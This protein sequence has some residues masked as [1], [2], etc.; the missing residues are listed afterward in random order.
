MDSHRLLIRL[1]QQPIQLQVDPPAVQL[2][3]TAIGMEL[4]VL[5]S[6][7]TLIP[8]VNARTRQLNHN[9]KLPLPR[10]VPVNVTEFPTV[11]GMEMAVLATQASPL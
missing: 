3:P 1:A 11:T 10:L 5:V 7:A 6:P 4:L 2:F 9:L 8:P